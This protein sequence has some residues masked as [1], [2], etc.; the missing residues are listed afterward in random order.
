MRVGLQ[1]GL[2][3]MG[4]LTSLA[5][6]TNGLRHPTGLCYTSSETPE[7]QWT[8]RV[9][10]GGDDQAGLYHSSLYGDPRVVAEIRRWI[11]QLSARR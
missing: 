8:H 4:A 6:G 1:A 10:T 3:L 2:L 7:G 9:L 11:E 5:F